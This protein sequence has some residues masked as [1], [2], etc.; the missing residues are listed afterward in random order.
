[1]QIKGQEVIETEGGNLKIKIESPYMAAGTIYNFPEKSIGIGINE[2]IVEEA[3]IRECMIMVEFS[4]NLYWIRPSE[5]LEIVRKHESKELH[6]NV[7]L[8]IVPLKGLHVI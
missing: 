3:A 2:G 7:N 5:I 8:L 1:M 6:G 4:N